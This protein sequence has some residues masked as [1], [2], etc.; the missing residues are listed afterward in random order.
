LAAAAGKVK[1][2]AGVSGVLGQL[3]GPGAAAHAGE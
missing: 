1:G 3:A 2:G